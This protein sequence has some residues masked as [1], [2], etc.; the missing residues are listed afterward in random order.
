MEDYGR[1]E[2][3]TRV[4]NTLT[5]YVVPVVNVDGYSYTWI[6]QTDQS[7]RLWRKTRSHHPG[8][9]C[10][11]TDPNR[12]FDHKFGGTHIK[13]TNLYSFWHFDMIFH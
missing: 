5:V 6:N 7:H 12:N 2:T 1:D 4:L 3:V 10:I 9:V 13:N 8:D 11:G